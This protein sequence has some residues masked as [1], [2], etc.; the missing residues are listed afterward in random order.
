V[1]VILQSMDKQKKTSKKRR[2]KKSL[3]SHREGGKKQKRRKYIPNKKRS[4]KH[5]E[6][7]A[8][9]YDRYVD[10]S[11]DVDV[12]ARTKLLLSQLKESEESVGVP[13]EIRKASSHEDSFHLDLDQLASKLASVPIWTRLRLPKTLFV[14]TCEADVEGSVLTGE[15]LMEEGPAAWESAEGDFPPV[16]IPPTLVDGDTTSPLSLEEPSKSSSIPG[17]VAA[18]KEVSP[19][20]LVKKTSLEENDKEFNRLMKQTDATKTHAKAINPHDVKV[21]LEESD[22]ELEDLLDL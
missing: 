1:F 7:L 22:S 8:S 14:E 4:K 5:L 11:D 17:E 19:P 2:E 20:S 10:V 6:N 15:G 18:E 21:N 12:K 16:Y 9:N 3:R 13:P